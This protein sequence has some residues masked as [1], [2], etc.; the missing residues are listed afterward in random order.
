[1]TLKIFFSLEP[2]QIRLRCFEA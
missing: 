2:K 1:M